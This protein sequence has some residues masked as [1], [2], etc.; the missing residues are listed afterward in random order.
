[1]VVW[2]LGDGD[3]LYDLLEKRTHPLFVKYT[4][5]YDFL[6]CL[7]TSPC[8][9]W[10]NTNSTIREATTQRAHELNNVYKDIIATTTFNNFDI[11][12]YDLPI[13]EAI[14]RAEQDGY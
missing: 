5:F 10:M 11:Q 2:G 8:W 14:A 3:V 4:D 13:N 1:M 12:F 9:G 7:D 6:N